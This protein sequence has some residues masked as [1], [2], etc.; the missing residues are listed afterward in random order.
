MGYDVTYNTQVQEKAQTQLKSP[1]L[2][3]FQ[4]I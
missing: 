4:P 3:P 2:D 1:F